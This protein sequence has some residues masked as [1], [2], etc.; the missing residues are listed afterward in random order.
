LTNAPKAG[1]RITVIRRTGNTWYDR[2]TST[3]S[4]GKTLAKNTSA[5]SRF[6]LQK[7]TIMPE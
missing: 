6:I 5:I 3:A 2:G 7:T 1:T 4:A